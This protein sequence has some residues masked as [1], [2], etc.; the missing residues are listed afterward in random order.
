MNK[1]HLL[2]SALVL[3]ILVG[4]GAF[5]AVLLTDHAGISHAHFDRIQ[6][7]MTQKQVG[8]ILGG[9][10]HDVSPDGTHWGELHNGKLT[11]GETKVIWG[12]NYGAAVIVF[13][14]ADRVVRKSW[15]DS[16][17]PMLQRLRRRLGAWLRF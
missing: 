2:L 1:K 11:V 13:D 4:L 8:D 6:I 7:G 16:D 3:T 9:S 10:P 12:G 17:E 15:F 5:L 14:A